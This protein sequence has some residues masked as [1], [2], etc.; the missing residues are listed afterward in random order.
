MGSGST[1]SLDVLSPPPPP[2]PHKKKYSPLTTPPPPP[3]PPPVLECL[4]TES[5]NH[6]AGLVK[7]LMFTKGH[8]LTWPLHF[9]PTFSMNCKSQKQNQKDVNRIWL[10]VCLL[11]SIL[12]FS[13]DLFVFLVGVGNFW[14]FIC[15]LV[16]FTSVW[17]AVK[18][19]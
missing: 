5:Q 19:T 16:G 6:V 2:Y 18:I 14:L 17:C 7:Y 1:T 15:W 13:A 4:Q 10:S 3:P 12:V 11:V 8:L 9:P